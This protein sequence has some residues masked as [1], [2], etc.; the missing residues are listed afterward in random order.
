M[1]VIVCDNYNEMSKAGAKLIASQ[2]VLNPT[3][4]LGLATGSTP[5]GMYQEL[6]NMNK[7]GEIDFS[8]VTT[9]NL[10]E[11]YPISRE[12][13]QSYYYFMREK[14]FSHININPD[15]TNIPNGET[16]NPD[17]ECLDYEKKI[18]ASGGIDI[19][20]LGIGRNG[21][22]GFNEP[23]AAL[24]SHTHLT[25]LTENT[26]N[27]NSRF[28]E[29]GEVMPTEALTMGIATILSA[30]KIILLASGASKSRVVGELLNNKINTSIPATML[31]THPDVVL[32]CDKDAYSGAR[33]GVDIGGTD[34]KFAVVDGKKVVYKNKIKT[35]DSGEKIIESIVAEVNKIKKEYNIKTMGVGTPGLIKN[36]LV[37]A[38]NLDFKD[39][40]LESVLSDKADL[41]VTVD[42][43]ANC[44]ALGEIEFGVAKHCKDIVLVTLGTGV[45]GGVILGRQICHTENN[46]GEIGHIIIQADG[47]RPCPCGQEGCYEQ[48]ASISALCRDAEIAAN[49]N[50]DS[51]LYSIY[52]EN[53]KITGRTFYAAL[54][55]NCP[56]AKEVYKKYLKYLSVG[57]KSIIMAFGPDAVVLA[58]GITNE[59]ELL[60]NPLKELIGKT[61]VEIAI[62]S[63]QSDAGALG[64]CM[65]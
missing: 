3:S 41:P 65:L 60:L 33:L 64:A 29:D 42:N 36:G 34:I 5:V 57:I 32:I 53:G 20:V 16:D 52:K 46:M 35:E 63:L 10:D 31:K 12:N 9:F 17:K 6:I 50:T 56:V 18:K 19:Q 44:A 7:A 21:H 38:I 11:Y 37:T 28:F 45:G 30:K 27:A 59:G 49:K 22:I 58:G 24:N 62:S 13:R 55:D 51:K 8:G 40:P 4:V 54:K 39:L 23:D 26:L 47:G 61:D 48:Y 25:A 43:D 14:L 15:N 1:R 2:L